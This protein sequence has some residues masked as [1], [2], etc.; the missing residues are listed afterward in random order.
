M[1]YVGGGLL[2]AQSADTGEGKTQPL[3]TEDRIHG[4]EGGDEDKPHFEN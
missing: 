4:R 2:R 1:G 3:W